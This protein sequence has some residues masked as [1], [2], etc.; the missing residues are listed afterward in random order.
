MIILDNAKSLSSQKLM[1]FLEE[2]CIAVVP[3]PALFFFLNMLWSRHVKSSSAKG[4]KRQKRII[5]PKFVQ[6]EAFP[7]SALCTSL[8][9]AVQS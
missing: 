3:P 1:D 5:T 7:E 9:V 6:T 4:E 2:L 8:R